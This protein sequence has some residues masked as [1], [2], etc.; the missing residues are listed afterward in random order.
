MWPFTRHFSIEET[1]FLTGATDFHSHI[2]PGVDD[3][4]RTLKE[5]LAVLA[6]YRE[7]GIRE[8]WLT[9]HIMED[10]PNEP[11]DLRRRF[12]ALCQAY[13]GPLT[14]HLA[15]ENMMDALFEQRFFDGKLLPMGTEGR[16]HLLVETSYFNPPMRLWALFQEIKAQGYF[17]I[18]AHPER[19]VYMTRKDY[20]RLFDS[21]VL[22]QLN[23][24]SL[25][26]I[27]GQEAAAK[28]RKFLLDGRYTFF[29]SDIHRLEP[30]RRAMAQKALSGKE[31]RALNALKEK[32][33]KY[34][35]A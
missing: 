20:A 3:G 21:G 27:Y 8:V 11:E 5:S 23:L 14:L 2:L 13:D 35:K 26:G 30:F 28:S 33:E 24:M 16:P 12:D 1:G 6:Y 25:T 34:I 22:L 19:Y 31:V 15:A 29:G 7:A 4:I 32:N 17:P 10:F 9:P 18:L